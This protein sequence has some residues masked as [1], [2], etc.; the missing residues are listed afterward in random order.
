MRNKNSGYREDHVYSEI[1]RIKLVEK[2]VLFKI[3]DKTVDD[4]ITP[5]LTYHL[6]LIQCEIL[7]RAYKHVLKLPRLHSALP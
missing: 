6:A 1:E 4:S 2:T 7:R 3:R 5:V